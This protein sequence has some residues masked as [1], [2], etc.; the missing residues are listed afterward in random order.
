M[1]MIARGLGKLWYELSAE[2]IGQN[3]YMHLDR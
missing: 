2:E 3:N 1:L